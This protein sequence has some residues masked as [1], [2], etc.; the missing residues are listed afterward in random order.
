MDRRR[1]QDATLG[2]AVQK[3]NL[4]EVGLDDGLNSV[5]IFVGGSGNRG[6]ADRAAAEMGGNG[7]DY[8]PVSPIEAEGVDF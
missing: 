1:G 8:F 4:E 7:A 3:A 6:D 5:T 2:G